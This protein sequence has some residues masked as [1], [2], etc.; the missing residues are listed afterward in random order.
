MELYFTSG[1]QATFPDTVLINQY[2]FLQQ[3]ESITGLILTDLT[4]DGSL[5]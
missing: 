2:L 4:T 3:G 1:M 5:L